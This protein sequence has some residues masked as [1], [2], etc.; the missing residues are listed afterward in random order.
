MTSPLEDESCAGLLDYESHF[1]EFIPVAEHESADPIALEAHE[2]EEGREYYL[3]MTTL[4]GLYRYDIHDIVR[5]DGFVGCC[6]KLTF[7]NKGAHYSSLT[8]EKL[9]ELHVT[10]A[11][12]QAFRDADITIEHYSLV[13][14]PGDPAHYLLLVEQQLS[15]EQRRRAA[16]CVDQR[17]SQVNCEYEDRL[18][19]QRLGPVVIASVPQGT[20]AEHRR[21]QTSHEGS[22]SYAYKHPFLAAKPELAERFRALAAK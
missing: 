16:Q 8:G 10:Q 14:V 1:F 5:C 6:P 17:L 11:I 15:P 7:M 12:G 20:W 3:L 18:Q 19:S 22:D 2:L 13:P 21:Q 9:S 4:S